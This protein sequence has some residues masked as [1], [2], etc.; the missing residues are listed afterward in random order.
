MFG[1]WGF[2][3][4]HCSWCILFTSGYQLQTIYWLP[5][6]CKYWYYDHLSPWCP[7]TS[8]VSPLQHLQLATG[9]LHWQ[10]REPTL[11][12]TK[13]RRWTLWYLKWR[14]HGES[15]GGGSPGAGGG[16]N[17]AAGEEIKATN[18]GSLAHKRSRNKWLIRTNCMTTMMKQVIRT[19][20]N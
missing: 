6:T 4:I 20:M 14:K 1:S 11:F 13:R 19:A 10:F 18:S 2:K 17:R 16:P 8:P 3:Y 12:D 5:W 9:H 7:S 15:Y